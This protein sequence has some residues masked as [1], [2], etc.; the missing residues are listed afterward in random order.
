MKQGAA[1]PISSAMNQQ[2]QIIE[3]N[4]DPLTPRAI[5]AALDE[6]IIGQKDAKKAVAVALRNR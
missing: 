5:V 3:E 2:F 1:H 4:A 6:H